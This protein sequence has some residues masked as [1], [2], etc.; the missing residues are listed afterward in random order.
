METATMA[1]I[2]GWLAAHGYL[3]MPEEKPSEGSPKEGS[4]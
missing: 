3:H 4:A 1:A 2:A